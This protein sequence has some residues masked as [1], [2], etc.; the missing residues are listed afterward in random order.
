VRGVRLQ[1]PLYASM[2]IPSL[3]PPFQVQLF[4]LAPRWEH[5][6]TRATFEASALRGNAGAAIVNTLRTLVQGI[7]RREFFILPDSYC[8]HCA[9]TVA[10]RRNDQA[11]WWRSYRAPQAR[12]LR[13]LRK[14]KVTDE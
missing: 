1:P 9:F 12:Q 7:E 5:P 4:Y 3:P 10:C 6:I 13:R 2:T 14:Q 11:T 8:E